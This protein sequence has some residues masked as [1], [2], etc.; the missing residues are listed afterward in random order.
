MTLLLASGWLG[1]RQHQYEAAGAVIVVLLLLLLVLLLTMERRKK[2][3]AAGGEVA[4]ERPPKAEK[5]P[6]PEKAPRPPKG[7]KSVDEVAQ[8]LEE[9]LSASFD[10]LRAEEQRLDER[11]VALSA[12]EAEFERTAEERIARLT[13]W[14]QRLHARESQGGAQE[15]AAEQTFRQRELDLAQRAADLAAREAAL[16]RRA[17]EVEPQP[18][19]QPP[20]G[21]DVDERERAL[22]E[23]IAALSHRELELAR[24]SAELALRERA[25]AVLPEQQP[26]QAAPPPPPPEPEPAPEPVPPAVGSAGGRW[27]V[28]ALDRLVEER[29]KE[30]PDRVE[31]WTSYLYSLRSYASPDGSLPSSFDTLIEE[32]FGELV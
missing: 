4:A 17:A 21:S 11:Q 28:H 23:R 5:L 13:E 10:R 2:A 25:A 8:R 14:E 29:G 32:T 9:R 3:A 24:K 12:S 19:V 27:N 15:A 31:E 18:Q 30:F 1:T 16:A 26:L 20:A 22:A 6:K 7:G